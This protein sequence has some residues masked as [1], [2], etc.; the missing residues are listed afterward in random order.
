MSTLLGDHPAEREAEQVDV[1]FAERV[2]ERGDVVGHRVDVIWR[3]SA[4]AADS[5][6][7]EQND[8]TFIGESIDDERI[9]IVHVSAKALQHDERNA[10]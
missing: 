1:S 6:A 7:V 8:G 4:A 10:E 2:D 5:A 9:P 3:R